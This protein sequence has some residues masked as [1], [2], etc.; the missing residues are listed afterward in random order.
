[1][2]VQIDHKYMYATIQNDEKKSKLSRW[3][4]GWARKNTFEMQTGNS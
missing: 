2:F 3:V 1:M 4:S